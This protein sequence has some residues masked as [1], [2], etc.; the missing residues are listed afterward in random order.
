MVRGIPAYRRYG[1]E[2][3]Q[4]NPVSRAGSPALTMKKA[5]KELQR[6]RQYPVIQSQSIA[7]EPIVD[8]GEVAP[9]WDPVQA[10]GGP[11][12]SGE[13]HGFFHTVEPSTS[14]MQKEC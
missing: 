7:R 10:Q 4:S 13:R 6:A 3:P 12:I 11:V 14:L 5:A 1:R 9:V 2:F 8:E